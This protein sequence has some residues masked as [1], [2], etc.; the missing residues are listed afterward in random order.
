MKAY[1]EM[2]HQITV[3]LFHSSLFHVCDI[4][5]GLSCTMPASPTP[6]IKL[7]NVEDQALK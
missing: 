1:H 4:F 6:C 5:E 3:Y 7:R 2:V